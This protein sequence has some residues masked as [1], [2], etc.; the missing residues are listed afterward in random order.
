MKPQMVVLNYIYNE[1][2]LTETTNTIFEH[3]K[4]EGQIPKRSF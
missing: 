4:V 2:L 1:L 3:M